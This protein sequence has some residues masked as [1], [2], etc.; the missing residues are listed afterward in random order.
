MSDSLT[1]VENDPTGQPNVS[2][3]DRIVRAVAAEDGVE[4]L[5]LP[6]PLYEAIDPD[7]LEALFQPSGTS[8]NDSKLVVTF[9]YGGYSVTVTN[10]EVS[11][12]ERV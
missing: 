8:K 5:E 6:T 4:P 1:G 10:G 3:S 12:T 2:L 11:L 7:A 9:P